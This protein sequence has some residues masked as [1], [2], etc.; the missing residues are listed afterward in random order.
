MIA[1]LLFVGYSVA[2]KAGGVPQPSF[3]YYSS[4]EAVGQPAQCEALDPEGDYVKC[5]IAGT[6]QEQDKA[7]GIVTEG[8][9]D[10][11]LPYIQDEEDRIYIEPEENFDEYLYYADAFS[12]PTGVMCTP[13]D[14]EGDYVRCLIAGAN[15]LDGAFG[16]VVDDGDAIPDQ[17]LEF[18]D[19]A[20]GLV[21]DE[22]D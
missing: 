11:L 4:P 6:Q 15:Q 13:I 18:D 14:P 3:T 9:F 20:F 22:I 1:S 16:I 17:H 12:A 10:Y 2:V 21:I 7:F 5:M 19:K 8:E